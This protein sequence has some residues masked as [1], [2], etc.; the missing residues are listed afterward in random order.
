[1]LKNTQV[2]YDNARQH[3]G[4][5]MKKSDLGKVDPKKGSDRL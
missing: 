5:Y 4:G 3:R 1:M 2:L